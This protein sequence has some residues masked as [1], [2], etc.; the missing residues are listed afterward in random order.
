[1]PKQ[2]NASALFTYIETELKAIEP[3]MMDARKNEYARA[4]KAAV[5]M[6]LAKLYLNA[7]AAG[8]GAK[9]A[10]AATYAKKVIDAGYSL[11][12]K[13]TNLFRTDN[14]NSKEIVFPVA[15]DGVHTKTWGG[16]T[17]LFM[18]Q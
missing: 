6:L 2:T 5:W 17:F 7:E 3:D 1:L 15:F 11:E 9:Y 12:S 4:D 18:L 13:Y 16:M 10:D 14:N 8:V